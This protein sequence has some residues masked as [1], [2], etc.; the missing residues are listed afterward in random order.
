MR[1]LAILRFVLS[2][3]GYVNEVFNELTRDK[4]KS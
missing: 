1:G 3:E 2:N 4:A